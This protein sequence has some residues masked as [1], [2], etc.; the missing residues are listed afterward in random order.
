MNA[1]LASLFSLS[2]KVKIYVPST[3][4]VNGAASVEQIAA[5]VLDVQSKLAVW[6]GGSTA[7]SAIGAWQ[8]ENVGTVLEEVTIVE[9]FA[10]NLSE[11]N[12]D[13][14]ISLAEEIKRSMLQESVAIEINNV[15]YLV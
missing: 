2:H 8:S 13:N 4:Y 9:S 14:L 11:E 5:T 12:I 3:I 1:K 15:L 10:S 7:Y 6:F